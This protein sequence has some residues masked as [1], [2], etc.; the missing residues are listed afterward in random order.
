MAKNDA[1]VVRNTRLLKCQRCTG[2]HEFLS[3]LSDDAP[4]DT[5]GAFSHEVANNMSKLHARGSED[6]ERAPDRLVVLHPSARKLPV[7]KEPELAQF[8]LVQQHM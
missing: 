3:L 2:V 8:S 7:R 6:V 1:Y 4:C 5:P